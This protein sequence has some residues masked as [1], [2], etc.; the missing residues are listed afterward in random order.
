MREGSGKPAPG[1]PRSGAAGPATS[2]TRPQPARPQPA[3]RGSR[4]SAGR[5]HVRPAGRPRASASRILPGP[6]LRPR[7]RA[8]TGAVTLR[9]GAPW[10]LP[11]WI[12]VTFVL[13]YGL[14]SKN[15]RS[16]PI[17]PWFLLRIRSVRARGAPGRPA[18]KVTLR[19]LQPACCSVAPGPGGDGRW[20]TDFN[21]TFPR[22]SEA[23][24]RFW[25]FCLF[26]CFLYELL[27]LS[28]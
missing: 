17:F 6:D 11:Q 27:I 22:P 13:L 4:D 26:V 28:T 3:G 16:Q 2:T 18:C 21:P 10:V 1:L 20:G 19:A 24:P 5:A 7:K 25:F 15:S 12:E 8:G 23:R 9:P 14:G